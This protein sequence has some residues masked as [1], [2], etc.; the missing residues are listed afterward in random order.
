[1]NV[2]SWTLPL[3]KSNTMLSMARHHCDISLKGAVLPLR[4]DMK[5]GFT[6]LLHASVKAV[7]IMQDLI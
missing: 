3:V 1:M 7:S 5:M 6:N 2:V 4:N